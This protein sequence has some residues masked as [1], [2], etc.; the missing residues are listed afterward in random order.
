MD[1]YAVREIA[2]RAGQPTLLTV[3]FAPGSAVLPND[4]ARRVRELATIVRVV[5]RRLVAVGHTDNVGQ[6]AY[7]L[8]LSER[9]AAH[10]ARLLA[11]AG[12]PS[13]RLS[14]YG[15][16]ALEPDADNFDGVSARASN[17]RVVVAFEHRPFG[18]VATSSEPASDA[19][20]PRP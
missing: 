19:A 6:P 20:D 11:V 5:R 10:V 13:Y 15:R 3:H 18:V 1:E 4:A 16:G 2:M 12:I 9:R 14:A 8:L 7:N 17:R